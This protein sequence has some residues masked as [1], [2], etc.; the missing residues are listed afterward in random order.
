MQDELKFIVYESR[1]YDTKTL[2]V[3]MNGVEQ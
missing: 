2:K 3:Y 1:L